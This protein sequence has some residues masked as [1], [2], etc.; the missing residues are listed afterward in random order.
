[1]PKKKYVEK[2]FPTIQQINAHY[3]CLKNGYKIYPNLKSSGKFGIVVEHSVEGCQTKF[4]N[5]PKEY[6]QSEI[7]ET[8][9]NLAEHLYLRHNDEIFVKKHK[10]HLLK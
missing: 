2:Y 3:W 1:M 5:S 4:V 7:C 8:T 10:D 9:Y 6:E